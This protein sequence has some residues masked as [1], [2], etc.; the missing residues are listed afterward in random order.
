[1]EAKA[2]QTP[3]SISWSHRF[4]QET[5]TSVPRDS[6]CVGGHLSAYIPCLWC[7]YLVK[8]YETFNGWLF[9]IYCTLHSLLYIHFLPFCVYSPLIECI[10]GKRAWHTLPH[11]L[12]TQQN[13]TIFNIIGGSSRLLEESRLPVRDSRVRIQF[14]TRHCEQYFFFYP[15]LKTFLSTGFPLF[16]G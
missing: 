3:K 5:M 8:S 4:V 15:A 12:S 10:D 2:I 9:N 13:S 16:G 1:M 11:I 14:R 7:F 6:L